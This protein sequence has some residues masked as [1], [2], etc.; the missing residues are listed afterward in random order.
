M[1]QFLQ[2]IATDA[3]SGFTAIAGIN[4]YLYN[5]LMQYHWLPRVH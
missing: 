2:I 3:L 4:Q 1:L 5:Q